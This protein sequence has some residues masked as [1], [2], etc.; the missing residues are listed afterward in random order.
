MDNNGFGG[1]N[2]NNSQQS[3][4]Y[5]KGFNRVYEGNYNNTNYDPDGYDPNFNGGYD[6][7][8][9][10]EPVKNS[11]LGF[12]KPDKFYKCPGKEITG[13]I[14]GIASMIWGIIGIIYTSTIR[15]IL[16]AYK[17]QYGSYVTKYATAT[18]TSYAV[19]YGLAAII[20][21]VIV[22]ILRRKV[23]DQADIVTKKIGAGFV[24]SIIGAI[25][26]II[27]I[28]IGATM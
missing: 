7:R 4:G 21:F 17:A 19:I 6:P 28:I 8:Q 1:F 5:D 14:L 23:Y 22:F 10:S 11:P 15:S 16:S 24:M 20:L 3:Y 12:D 27:T 2:G 13:L 9:Y 18:Y 26:G 25:L